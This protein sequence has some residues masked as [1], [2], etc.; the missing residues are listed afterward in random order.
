MLNVSFPEEEEWK[1]AVDQGAACI[2]SWGQVGSCPGSPM[3]A[4]M[5]SL[6]WGARST[7]SLCRFDS[8]KKQAH[9]LF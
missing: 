5:P 7:H 1:G 4:V 3:L 2:K 8:S 6:S 9:L